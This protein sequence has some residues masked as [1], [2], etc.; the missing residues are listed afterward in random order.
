V[1][2]VLPANRVKTVDA[3]QITSGLFEKRQLFDIN[4]DGRYKEELV[5]LQLSTI[6]LDGVI[7][8]YSGKSKRIFWRC[9]SI[10]RY[11]SN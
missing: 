4:H 7:S 5:P 6:D 2:G 3:T 9:C 1:D 10:L 8:I 11:H